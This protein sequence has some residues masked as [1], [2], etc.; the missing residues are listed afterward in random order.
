[1]FARQDRGDECKGATPFGQ[2]DA[3]GSAPPQREAGMSRAES[4]RQYLA[5]SGVSE[6]RVQ[7]ATCGEHEA[8]GHDEAMWAYDRRVELT[9]V[10]EPLPNA[11]CTASRMQ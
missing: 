3:L 10:G 11:Q 7:L 8:N 5:Q 9:L 4:A 1:M 6:A 2:T